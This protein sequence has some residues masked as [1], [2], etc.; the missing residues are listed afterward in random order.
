MRKIKRLKNRQGEGY[1]D[2]AVSVLVTVFTLVFVI[3]VF[4]L[5]T[6]KQELGYVCQEMVECAAET[7]KIDA[8]TDAR[9]AELCREVGFTPERYLTACYF[10]EAAGTVQLGDVISCTVTYRMQ[11]IGF[12]DF[13]I[14]VELSVTR[15]ALSRVYWK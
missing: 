15:S 3:N 13:S 6:V 2:A 1:I 11:F 12:G 10:D 7:G 14:P 5:M 9:F 4:S 8:D